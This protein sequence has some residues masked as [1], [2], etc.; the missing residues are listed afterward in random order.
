M[1]EMKIRD[2]TQ[3]KC[4]KSDDSRILVK[5]DKIKKRWRV[6]FEKLLNEKQ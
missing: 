1:R 6:Y 5:D 2:F 4:I 3:V